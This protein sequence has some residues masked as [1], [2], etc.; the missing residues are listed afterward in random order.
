MQVARKWHD[1]ERD[2]GEK[3]PGPSD[4]LPGICA[5][6]VL[7]LR[8]LLWCLSMDFSHSRFDSTPRVGAFSLGFLL[9]CGHMLHRMMTPDAEGQASLTSHDHLFE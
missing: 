3:V 5:W 2:G 1:L 9:C 6:A 8:L 4:F 7:A